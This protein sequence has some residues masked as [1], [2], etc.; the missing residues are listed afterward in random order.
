[1][2]HC[3]HASE[4]PVISVIAKSGS[5]VYNKRPPD[6][7]EMHTGKLKTREESHKSQLIP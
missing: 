1:M 3:F 7:F 6:M 2:S 4:K 5:K